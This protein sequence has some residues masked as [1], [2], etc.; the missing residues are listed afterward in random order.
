MRR[1]VHGGHR[2][3]TARLLLRPWDAADAAPL[4]RAV[5]AS[6]PE[7]WPWMPWAREWPAEP[8]AVEERLMGFAAAFE[9]GRDWMY[10]IFD[11]ADGSVLGGTGLHP[12]VGPDAIEIGYWIRTDVTRRGYATEAAAALTRVA[13]EL[14]EVD[15]VEIRCDE[16]NDASARVPERL[17]Y[18]RVATID[19]PLKTPE[20]ATQRRHVW[21][22]D[23]KG[24]A[25]SLPA[26]A[27]IEIREE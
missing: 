13:F 7:L 23:R 21:S 12:R 14:H 10:G 4:T 20:G 1:A 24:Y 18:R 17:G 3:L 15:H 25:A 22:L 6:L 19:S 8:S 5:I 9:E 26:R 16:W 2:V 11:P 27:K